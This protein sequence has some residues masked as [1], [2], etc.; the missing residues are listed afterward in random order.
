[1][2]MVL[3]CEQPLLRATATQRPAFEVRDREVLPF[4]VERSLALVIEKELLLFREQEQLKADLVT[5]FDYS[6]QLLF[7]EI[8]D[9]SYKYIDV[10]NMKRFLM[11][12]SVYPNEG[13][14]K[15]IIRRLDTD[16]DARLSFQE[17]TAAV[18][19]QIEVTRHGRTGG[20]KA[21][22]P[23]PKNPSTAKFNQSNLGGT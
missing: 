19:P 9:W 13:I 16:G 2:Q 15:S 8:D 3:P 17:F 23:L 12:S 7:R 1:M 10:K 18:T 5:R 11:K 21:S 6:A 20:F 14:L 4:E 22:L